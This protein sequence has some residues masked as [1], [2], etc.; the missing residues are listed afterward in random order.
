MISELEY[1]M[2]VETTKMSAS[3]DIR[4][5]WATS[6]EDGQAAFLK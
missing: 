5:T 6:P 4:T 2:Y 3:I 1:A